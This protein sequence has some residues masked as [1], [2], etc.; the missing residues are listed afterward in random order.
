M[1]GGEDLDGRGDLGPGWEGVEHDEEE[2]GG[3]VDGVGFG[4]G[5][6]FPDE[7]GGI[8]RI[9]ADLNEED[10]AGG[11]GGLEI[12]FVPLGGAQVVDLAAEHGSGRSGEEEPDFFGIENASGE[13]FPT[14]NELDFVQQEGDSGLVAEFRVALEIGFQQERGIGGFDASEALVFEVEIDEGFTGFSGR[15]EVGQAL[16]EKTGFAT[17]PHADH[18]ERLA[19]NLGEADLTSRQARDWRDEGIG[20]F[21]QKSRLDFSF[22]EREDW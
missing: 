6:G 14:G 18:G 4:E 13:R 3:R 20:R 21:F 19:R 12:D 10:L 16:P 15:E 5:A 9:C 11:V 8:G 1:D 17:A 2:A 7:G 22:H